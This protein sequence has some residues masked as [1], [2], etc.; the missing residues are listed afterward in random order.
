MILGNYVPWKHR[1]KEVDT[2]KFT[3]KREDKYTT[4]SKTRFIYGDMNTW[5][6]R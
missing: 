1:K 5:I 3:A 4:T 2:K 6:N